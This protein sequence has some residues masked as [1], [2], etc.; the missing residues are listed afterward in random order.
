MIAIIPAKIGAAK[1]VPPAVVRFTLF[2][3]R[4]P[5]EQLPVMPEKVVSLEQ[6]RYGAFVG[7]ELSEMSGTRRKLPEVM[8]GTPVCHVGLDVSV[9]IPPPPAAR[10]TIV[11]VPLVDVVS[12]FHTS[13]GM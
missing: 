5:C 8:P 10:T 11:V 2:V 6:R 1:L 7:E 12:S 9:L 13:S 3:S 4:K